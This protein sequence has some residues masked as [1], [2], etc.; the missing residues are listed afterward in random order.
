MLLFEEQE[1]DGDKGA[2]RNEIPK[3]NPKKINIR[4]KSHRRPEKGLKPKLKHKET[5]P[6]LELK[7]NYLKGQSGVGGGREPI[8]LTSRLP[9]DLNKYVK[10]KNKQRHPMSSRRTKQKGFSDFPISLV[11][12][13]NPVLTHLRPSA[14]ILYFGLSI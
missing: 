6:S 1:I 14:S 13:T 8:S 5:L 4:P 12:K 2:V 11:R 7:R 9:A 10:P 3:P